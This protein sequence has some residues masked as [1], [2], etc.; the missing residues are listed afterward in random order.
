M[1][2]FIEGHKVCGPHCKL[3]K[4]EI[5]VL[6]RKKHLKDTMILIINNDDQ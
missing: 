4:D 3:T 5:L 1:Y 2:A 6:E